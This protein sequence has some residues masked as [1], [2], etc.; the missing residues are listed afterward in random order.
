MI[1]PRDRY[2]LVLAGLLSTLLHLA[3]LKWL[4][5]YLQP[6]AAF[7][8]LPETEIVLATRSDIENDKAAGRHGPAVGPEE[9]SGNPDPF[10]AGRRASSGSAE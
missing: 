4:V 9:P 7:A 10:A 2:A 6:P 3:L 1:S 5:A 8:P